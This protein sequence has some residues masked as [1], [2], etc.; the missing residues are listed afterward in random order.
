MTKG[1]LPHRKP[2]PVRRL[3][4]DSDERFTGPPS[5]CGL[6]IR[7]RRS[8]ARITK[9]GRIQLVGTEVTSRTCFG[10]SRM[11]RVGKVLHGT[12]NNPR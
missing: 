12:C 5:P 4:L 1:A 2:C 9:P 3:Q 11:G 7:T 6:P 10:T 8:L